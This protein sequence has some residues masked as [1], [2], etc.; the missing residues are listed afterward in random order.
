MPAEFGSDSTWL[1]GKRAGAANYTYV[2]IYQCQSIERGNS[3][4]Y[5]IMLGGHTFKLYD[6]VYVGDLAE[7]AP[8]EGE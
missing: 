8:E 1:K 5:I 2:N 6:C 7:I 3:D 4:N